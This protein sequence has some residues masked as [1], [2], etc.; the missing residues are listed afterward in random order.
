MHG[1][2]S[3]FHL[4]GPGKQAPYCI[5]LCYIENAALSLFDGNKQSGIRI[6]GDNIISNHNLF[7]KKH[8]LFI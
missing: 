3:M 1:V 7:L 5:N 6:I 8:G 2:F 4:C